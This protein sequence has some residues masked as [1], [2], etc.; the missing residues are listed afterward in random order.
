M[1][2]YSEKKYG[3]YLELPQF[4]NGRAEQITAYIRTALRK[5]IQFVEKQ[6][7]MIASVTL[8]K[9]T[10]MNLKFDKI[11]GGG[12]MTE[13]NWKMW[14]PH[15]DLENKYFIC[16][17]VDDKEIARES[18]D[19]YP[20]SQLIHFAVVGGQALFEVITDALPIITESW[21]FSPEDIRP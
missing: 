17:A 6:K 10:A 7:T 11:W 3:V 14:I 18:Q 19:I 12:K 21:E 4:T 8:R 2:L 13:N 20:F 9:H 16:K 15:D 5:A 1:D